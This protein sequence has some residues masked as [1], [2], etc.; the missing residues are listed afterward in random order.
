MLPVRWRRFCGCQLE[1]YSVVAIRQNYRTAVLF[2]RSYHR[3][4]LNVASVDEN[5]EIMWN[6][7][8]RAP[9]WARKEYGKFVES[10]IF[11]YQLSKARIKSLRLTTGLISF[12]KKHLAFLK[13]LPRSI[14]LL[15][16]NP[17]SLLPAGGHMVL[18]LDTP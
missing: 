7:R 4:H 6:G 2:I 3:I 17:R 15:S 5:L 8:Y 1:V 18:V 12:C 14:R 16:L 10:M 11:L 9:D 13:M